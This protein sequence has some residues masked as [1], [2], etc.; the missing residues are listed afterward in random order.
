[1]HCSTVE[2]KALKGSTNIHEPCMRVTVRMLSVQRRYV[3]MI[4]ADYVVIHVVGFGLPNQYT[5]GSWI[6]SRIV[7][8]RWYVSVGA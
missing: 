7:D 3:G 8:S 4:A 5:V 1:M 6:T 2:V